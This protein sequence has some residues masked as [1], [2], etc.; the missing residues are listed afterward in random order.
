MVGLEDLK[1]I[2]WQISPFLVVDNMARSSGQ[3]FFVVVGWSTNQD[4]RSDLSGATIQLSRNVYT[5]LSV[6]CAEYMGY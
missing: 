4:S 1:N 2:L 5:L 6:K 3:C